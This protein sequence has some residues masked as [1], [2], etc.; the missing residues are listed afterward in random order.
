[1]KNRLDFL[2]REFVFWVLF[3]ALGR[4]LFLIYH[5]E[6]LADLTFQD[7]LLIPWFGLR[8]DLSMAGYML[9][10]PSILMLL[11]TVID[12]P[13]GY[14]L[15]HVFSY[16]VMLIF[17]ILIVSDIELYSHWNFRMDATPLL[18]LGKDTPLA[19]PAGHLFW[20]SCIALLFVILAAFI[21]YR[22]I[23][24]VFRRILPLSW[25][26]SYVF[27]LTTLVLILPIRGGIGIAPLNTGMV[28]FHPTNTFANH[29]AVNVI[30]NIGY[31]IR[32][33]NDRLPENVL[34]SSRATELMA[35]FNAAVDEYPIFL[36]SD[37]PNILLI[38][39][40]SYTSKLIGMDRNEVEVSPVL[41]SLASHGLSFNHFYAS[42]TRT[43]K[44]IVAILN[45]YPS[46]PNASI[47]KFPRKTQ[48]LP[49][50]N[51]K[52]S[53]EGYH[54]S[55][56]Y[57]GDIDFANFRSYLN[58]ARFD[59]VTT[60]DNFP[61]SLNTSKWGV[62]DEYVFNKVL[63]EC[64]EV[65][66]P[67]FKTVLT[68]SSH[69]PFD[70]PARTIFDGA[71]EESQFIN[72]AHY[73]DRVLGEFLEKARQSDWWENTWVIITA[74]HGHRLPEDH[75]LTEPERYRI[76]MIWIGG[77]VKE[78]TKV[79]E[80]FGSQT[81]IAQTILSQLNLRDSSFYFSRN[82][83][84][85]GPFSSAVYIFNNGFGVIGEATDLIYDHETR[86][87]LREEGSA[88]QMEQGKAFIQAL[89]TDY[90]NR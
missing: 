28:Y 2:L 3:F 20:L 13:L 77:A 81:D 73:T 41:D 67:F 87:W 61:D 80:T 82:I 39:L 11:S 76:P 35:D 62:H 26:H 29:A 40:E 22:F 32:K 53:E 83:L 90:N 88:D 55:F 12:I 75:G 14:R 7:I 65:P 60:S 48:S 44:G 9:I 56:T 37:R 58:N 57:G 89:H 23:A 42:G 4:I 59:D 63:Q 70:V 19:I 85:P 30:W 45:G 74:D 15:I 46:Q 68:L 51:Q 1:M 6:Y 34:E 54:T 50:L 18:Y 17:S 84:S 86:A 79:L 25:K 21:Y 78:G 49:Y 8:M 72:S 36:S 33:I 52:L 16:F 71:D 24:S 43:D 27:L 38:V 66:K 31:S 10:I 47:I 64:A 69:E 5:V